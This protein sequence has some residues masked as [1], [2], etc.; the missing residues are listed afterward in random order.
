MTSAG[1][2]FHEFEPHT[3]LKHAI[4]RGYLERW[5]RILLSHFNRLRFVDACAGHGGD[6]A[7]NPGSPVIAAREC[8]KAAADLTVSRGETCT[9]DVVAIEKKRGAFLELRR[10]TERLGVRTHHGTLADIMNELEADRTP[11]LYFVDPFGMEPLRADLIRR[12]LAGPKNE[13]LLLFAGQAALRHFG[14]YQAR[15]LPP[16]S[17]TEDLFAGLLDV[18]SDPDVEIRAERA[19][20]IMDAA[21]IDGRWREVLRIPQRQRLRVFLAMYVEQLRSFG[22]SHVFPIPIYDP[23]RALKYHLIHASRNGKAYEVM[24]DAL[25]RAITSGLTGESARVLTQATVGPQVGDVAAGV[26]ER[27]SGMNGIPWNAPGNALSIRRY[28]LQE[29]PLM[30]WQTCELRTSLLPFRRVGRANVYDFPAP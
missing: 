25:A 12:A 27:F 1:T 8:R 15:E 13:V 22:A 3:L 6:E 5:A 26:R 17:D 19:E 4:L 14:L 24:K 23:G 9:V 21:F 30:R 11:T 2:H 10:R 16:G 18:S 28:A 29:T 20:E 7:G